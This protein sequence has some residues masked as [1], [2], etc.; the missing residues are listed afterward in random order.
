MNGKMF[1]S[2]YE[3]AFVELLREESWQY[4]YGEQLHR[5]YTDTILEQDLRDYISSKYKNAGLSPYDI[6]QIVAKIRNVGDVTDYTSLLAAFK[7]YHEGF[8]YSFSDAGRQPFHFNYI[9]FENV[10]NNVFRCVNQFEVKEGNEDRRP[11]VVLFINGIPVCIIELKNPTDKNATIRD[12]HTQITVRYR[13]DIFSLLKYCALAVISDGSN[14][15]LGSVF[16]PYEFFYAWKKVHNE[17]DPGKGVD[18]MRSLIAG[19]L[20]TE[21]ILEI[22]RDFVFF[23]DCSQDETDVKE[24]EIVCRYP[25]FFATQMLRDNILAHLRSNG[26]DGKG[27][28]YFGA[29]GCG[30]TYTMLFLARQLALRCKK[31]LGTPTI[32]IIVDREDLEDQ[33]EGVLCKATDYMGDK[34]IRVF[35]SRQDLKNEMSARKTGGMYITTIQKFEETTGLLSDRSN[36]I[37][38]SDEAHR[39][40]TNLG[41]TLQ[42]NKEVKKDENGNFKK[43]KLGAFITYGFAKYLHDA[44]PNATYVGFTG[45][46]ID[47]TVQVFG[48]VVDR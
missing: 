38:F 22:L 21:R 2:E 48:E 36:I 43:T 41:S 8:D 19:A 26:G 15:R 39:S 18:Q 34:A 25:Q 35:D 3:E 1:E 47:E 45:T 32:L 17:D 4:T 27:G 12:A 44:L 46:P 14:T 33:A 10:E 5:K 40:Q 13:R 37:C 20:S 9:D 24:T 6:D 29:T 42:I 16:T 23:P 31:Q 11:D 7:L 30:K 28:T